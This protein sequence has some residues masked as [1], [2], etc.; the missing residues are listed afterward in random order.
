LG[1]AE[2]SLTL[3]N[4]NGFLPVDYSEVTVTRR[5][6]RSGESE[7]YINKTAC[8]LK[9]ILELFMDTGLGREGYSIIGQGRIDQIINTPPEERRGSYK[10]AGGIIKYKSRKDEAV[11]KLDKTLENIARVEEILNDIRNQLE[12]LEKQ[13]QVAKKYL[14]LRDMLKV[15]RI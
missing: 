12:P 6:F 2:V 4:S 3:D 9:D 5:V 8:R 7:Y 15:Y 13:S 14:K 11:R 10:E 1:F